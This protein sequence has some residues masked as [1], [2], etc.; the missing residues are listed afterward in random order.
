MLLC[1]I[2]DRVSWAR[3]Y[4]VEPHHVARAEELVHELSHAHLMGVA[5]DALPDLP[6]VYLVIDDDFERFYASHNQRDRQELRAFALGRAVLGELFGSEL[7]S[8]ATPMHKLSSAM[9]GRRSSIGHAV[10]ADELTMIGNTHAMQKRAKYLAELV[11]LRIAD[12][13]L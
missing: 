11:E 10:L 6:K 3:R 13:A 8:G 2:A 7:A 12:Q 4:G 9:V 5:L 1:A